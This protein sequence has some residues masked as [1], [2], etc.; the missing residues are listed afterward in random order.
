M[1]CCRN[2]SIPVEPQGSASYWGEYNCDTPF[3]LLNA[4][5]NWIRENLI[6]DFVFYTGDSASH[7]VIHQDWKTNFDAIKTVSELLSTL[8]KPIYSV[9]GNHDSFFVDQLYNKNPVINDVSE[10]FNSLNL[11]FNYSQGYYRANLADTGMDICGITSL[12]YDSNNLLHILNPTADLN[13]QFAWGKDNLKGCILLAHIYPRTSE[14]SPEFD[15]FIKTISPYREFY[16]HSHSDKFIIINANTTSPRVGLIPLSIV[17][18]GHFPGIRRYIYASPFILLDYEQFYLN[19]TKQ[20]E[21]SAFVGY[22]FSYSA[23][24]EYTLKDMTAE[25]WLDL[26]YRMQNDTKLYNKYC[27]NMNPPSLE[28]PQGLLCDISPIFC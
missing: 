15:E 8:G 21:K 16:G 13:D 7:W 24:E 26:A 11:T 6:Y 18:S 1:G 5:I 10:L 9:L 4:T 12:W 17:P 19:L 3:S 23:R 27:S 2:L 20:K 28:C 22:D 14:A 25:S